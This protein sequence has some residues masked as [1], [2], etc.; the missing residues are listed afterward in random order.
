LPPCPDGEI[1]KNHDP[2]LRS[3]DNVQLWRDIR[4]TLKNLRSRI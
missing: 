4:V 3:F 1:A 2:D